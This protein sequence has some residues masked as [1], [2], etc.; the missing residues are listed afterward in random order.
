MIQA[1]NAVT[2]IELEN[3]NGTK[4]IKKITAEKTMPSETQYES[5]GEAQRKNAEIEKMLDEAIA[6]KM[7]E[8]DKEVGLLELWTILWRDKW[9][10]VCIT[11]LFAT[12]SVLYSLSLPNIYKSEVLLAPSDENSGGGLATLA[13]QFGGLANLAGVNLGSEGINKT[14]LAIE[15]LKSRSF[16]THVI[17]K[18]DLLVP[19]MAAK[20]WNQQTN[21]LVIDPEVY[22]VQNKRWI[23]AVSPSKKTEP[24]PQEAYEVFTRKMQINFDNKTSFLSLS[25]EFYSPVIAKQWVDI[26]VKEINAV[27]KAREVNE[28]ERSIEYLKRQIEKT[29]VT[30]MR[31]VFFELIEKQTK[32]VMFAEVRDEYVFKTIDEA[33]IPEQKDKPKKSLICILGTMVGGLLAIFWVFLRN[34]LKLNKNTNKKS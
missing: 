2:I 11:F 25:V 15:V 23:R 5:G 30:D 31:A 14:D 24:S 32:V 21:E 16:I 33:V 3:D 19:L 22:D 18:Y 26:L 10:I 1:L 8:G 27:I 13:S 20:D 7:R 9:V 6:R 12:T 17:Q 28:A 34:F 29:S 4:C